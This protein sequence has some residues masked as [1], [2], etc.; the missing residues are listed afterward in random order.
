MQAYKIETDALSERRETR[1]RLLSWG[2]VIL[3]VAITVWLFFLRIS[4]GLREDTN[5]GWL[6]VFALLGAVVGA[7][8]LV[9]RE[10]LRRA[11][12]EMVFVLCDDG[13][14][15]RREGWP[16]VKIDFS[17]VDTLREG[18][19]WLVIYS[20]EPRRKIAIPNDVRGFDEI[21]AELVK[22]HPLSA[23]AEF[24]SRSFV[25]PAV[26]ILSWAAVLLVRD[27]RV[28]I[29]AGV[30][31]LIS[32]VAGSRRLWALL[33]QGSK[34]LLLWICL[35]FVWFSAILLIYLRVVRS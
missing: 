29:P 28:A 22:H 15:R 17:E 19:R 6:A 20:T 30:I 4:G 34:R 13:V 35:G 18:T 33:H 10:I 2:T 26:S 16:D 7:C 5:L 31:A 11:E 27:M 3:L 9:W 8:I 1:V 14:I 24:P 23:R 12:R 21:R 32:L 25:L